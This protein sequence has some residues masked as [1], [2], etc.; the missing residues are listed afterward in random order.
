M[1]RKAWKPESVYL[2]FPMTT[3]SAEKRKNQN[4]LLGTQKFWS[5]GYCFPQFR[6]QCYVAVFACKAG[7]LGLC[8]V[9]PYTHCMSVVTCQ[10]TR[11]CDDHAE[12]KGSHDMSHTSV[13][14]A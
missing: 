3:C 12:E 11:D 14:A 2:D 9:I 6:L 8:D 4:M 5:V 13:R 10:Q 1:C 7:Y